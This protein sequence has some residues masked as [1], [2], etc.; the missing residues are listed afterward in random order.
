MAEQNDATPVSEAAPVAEAIDDLIMAALNHERAAPGHERGSTLRILNSA[1]SRVAALAKPASSPAV[2][3]VATGLRAEIAH[4]GFTG[5]II[6]RYVTREGKR[7]A[8]VQQDGTRVVHVYG[9]KWLPIE[10][11]MALSQSTSAGRGDNHGS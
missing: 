1:R 3:D 8:V 10:T 9:E 6:G 11:Q 4:D 7:G 2:G 5:D